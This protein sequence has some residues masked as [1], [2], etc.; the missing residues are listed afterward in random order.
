MMPAPRFGHLVVVCVL[1][2]TLMAC[3]SNARFDAPSPPASIIEPWPEE[4]PAPPSPRH[5]LGHLGARLGR[6]MREGLGRVV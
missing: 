5:Y 4:P 6:P 3:S 1:T 2:Q